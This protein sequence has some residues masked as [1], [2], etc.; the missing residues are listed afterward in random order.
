[1]PGVL[2][3][4][5]VER[6]IMLDCRDIVRCDETVLRLG[7]VP[8]ETTLTKQMMI[9]RQSEMFNPLNLLVN[10]IEGR[11]ILLNEIL[12]FRGDFFVGGSLCKA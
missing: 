10:T 3:L 7:F 6:T 5:K 12:A 8:V 4:S 2:Y 9:Y 1:M 11:R